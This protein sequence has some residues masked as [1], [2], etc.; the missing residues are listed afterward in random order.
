MNKFNYG[1]YIINLGRECCYIKFG[2]VYKRL[3]NER[4]KDYYTS[5]PGINEENSIGIKINCD[6]WED[7]KQTRL[8]N[9]IK[10][11]LKKDNRYIQLQ[12]RNEWFMTYNKELEDSLLGLFEFFKEKYDNS[13]KLSI[14]ENEEDISKVLNFITGTNKDR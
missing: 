12:D 10:Q 13:I 3:P 5:N 6:L 4:L 9:L 14:L 11:E 7:D 2:D 1:Y 8:Q